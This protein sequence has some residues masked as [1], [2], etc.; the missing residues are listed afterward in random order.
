M[1]FS[2]VHWYIP[3]TLVCS[4]DGSPLHRTGDHS[5]GPLADE[6]TGFLGRG[7]GNQNGYPG[8]NILKKM[9]KKNGIP[10]GT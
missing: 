8:V 4:Q 7:N 6:K 5:T 9:W 3:P 1:L 10:F 2:P